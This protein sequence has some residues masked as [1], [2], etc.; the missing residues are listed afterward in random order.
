MDKL[1]D[2]CNEWFDGIKTQKF[3]TPQCRRKYKMNEAWF[4]N[5][6]KKRNKGSDSCFGSM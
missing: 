4:R 2:H 1:C 6:R 5:K 3:C